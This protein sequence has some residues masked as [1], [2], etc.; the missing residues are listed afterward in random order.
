MQTAWSERLNPVINQPLNGGLIVKNVMIESTGSQVNHGLG[1][2]PQGWFL[3]RKRGAGD[4]WD[5]QDTNTRPDLT[6]SL[7][8]SVTLKADIFIF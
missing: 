8:S 2:K 5:Q 3:V 6:L 1:R 7:I 4:V